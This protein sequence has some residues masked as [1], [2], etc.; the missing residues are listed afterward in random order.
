MIFGVIGLGYKSKLL[1]IEGT[2]DAA[3]YVENLARLGFMGELDEKYGVLN[4]IFQQGGAPCHTAQEAIDWIEENCD[5][6]SMWP[7]NS[8]DLNPIELSWAI[9]KNIVAKLTRK[10]VDELKKVLSDAWT[11]IPQATINKLCRSFAAR[12]QIWVE[13]KGESISEHLWRCC[14]KEAL[15]VWESNWIAPA[16]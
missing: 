11:S 6:L 1:F 2:V 9:L 13:M 14:D 7:A 16:P 8:P 15:L 3:N 4:W 12:L 5:L 10:I